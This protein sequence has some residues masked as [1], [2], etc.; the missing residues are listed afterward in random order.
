[1]NI[2][3]W[4]GLIAAAALSLQPILGQ[5]PPPPGEQPAQAPPAGKPENAVEVNISP[6]TAEVVRLAESGLGDEV[7]SSYVTNSQTA[8]NIDADDIV[9]LKDV[10]ISEAIISQMMAHDR[11]IR[12]SGP[13]PATAQTAPPPMP[14]PGPETIPQQQPI[15]QPNQ[16]VTPPNV[17]PANEPPPQYV[18][19]P[20]QE[21]NYFYS[22][23]APYGTWL[24]VDGIGWCWQ[25]RCVVVNRSWQPYSDYGHWAYT[26]CGW[27]WQS[28]YSWGWAPFHYGRW[29]MARCGWVW[30]PDRV[31]GP[32]WVSW[33]VAGDH[34]GWAPLPPF[35]TVDVH[36]GWL[37]RGAHVSVNFDF[38]LPAAHFTFVAFHDFGR[39]DVWHHRMPHNEVTRIYN[40]TTIVNNYTVVNNKVVNR[41]VAFDRVSAQSAVKIQRASIQDVP[42]D[43]RP[44]RAGGRGGDRNNNNVVYRH[45]LPST[46]KPTPQRVVAQKIDPNRTTV[47]RQTPIVPT[48]TEN[49]GNIAA[50]N[51][52]GQRYDNNSSANVNRG[53]SEAPS[54]GMR[55]GNQANQ[56]NR[57][58]VNGSNGSVDNNHGNA[59]HDVTPRNPERA[60]PNRDGV[61]RQQTQPPSRTTDRQVV[62]PPSVPRDN[63]SN[64]RSSRTETQ[65]SP[66]KPDRE[67]QNVP[68]TPPR[69]EP[70]TPSNQGQGREREYQSVPR[71]SN[72]GESQ[73]A[74]PNNQGREYQ[75]VPRSP[76]VY[77]DQPSHSAA[78]QNRNA[79]QYY[80]KGSQQSS[81]AHPNSRSYDSRQSGQS[82]SAPPARKSDDSHN[83]NNGNGNG[84]GAGAG[85]YNNGRGH[86]QDR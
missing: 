74:P 20:P 31:W 26:D 55:L 63:Q 36:G 43:R 34:C 10:G 40:R 75:S 30:M 3:T 9:Y 38:G 27:Y 47:V 64:S 6:A 17:P 29:Q 48:R 85:G 15:P 11:Q 16:V 2:K 61:P 83:S 13:P 78:A 22:D 65:A 76:R 84:N 49:R 52:G 12:E 42:S 33:R 1:M 58:P 66:T 21:V 59:S 24:Q 45:E 35:T 72:R 80:P 73:V 71:S 54:R 56:A 51:R 44:D 79:P 81:E 67:Y 25:P 77:G 7:V 70:Q 53:T 28:S 32:A 8:F 60:T 82:Y 50:G 14:T 57:P 86:G 18:S 39:H 23:L 37:Y 68:R 19:N 4:M 62:T 41:G 69:A 46:P 5:A